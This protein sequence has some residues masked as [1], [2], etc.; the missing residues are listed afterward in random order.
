MYPLLPSTTEQ[1]NI[2]ETIRRL[3]L[4]LANRH[5]TMYGELLA[6]PESHEA[7]VPKISTPAY[8]ANA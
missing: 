5:P 4:P 3:A 6:P 1:L 8:R 7:S 2:L